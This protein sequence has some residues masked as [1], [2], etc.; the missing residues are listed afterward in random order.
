METINGNTKRRQNSTCKPRCVRVAGREFIQS[1][2][3]D[4]FEFSEMPMVGHHAPVENAD[5]HS[6]MRQKQHAFKRE[7]ILVFP[8]KPQ[9]PIGAIQ[10]MINQTAGSISSR[11]RHG[12]QA[13]PAIVPV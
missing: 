1:K 2:T 6:P 10:N 3:P 4:P 12:I 8:E 7:K 11:S 9:A 13:Y 5:G